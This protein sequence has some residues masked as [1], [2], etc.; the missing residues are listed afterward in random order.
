MKKTVSIILA[1]I[2]IFVVASCTRGN[3][4]VLPKET[5]TEETGTTPA[6]KKVYGNIEFPLSDKKIELTV[7][8]EQLSD[9]RITDFETNMQ[10]KWYEELTN[11]HINWIA[12]PTAEKETKLNLSLASGDYPDIYGGDF[13]T[14]QATLYGG[15]VFRALN[16]LLDGGY[17]P[18]TKSWFEREP[19]ILEALT[20]PDGKLYGFP[21]VSIA[22]HMRA[23]NKLFVK[24]AWLDKLGIDAPTT[25]EEFRNMLIAFRDNDMDGDGDKGNEI[26][27]LGSISS[28]CGDPLIFL[29]NAFQF[30][31]GDYLIAKDNKIIFTANLDTW[32]EGLAYI[33]DLY[34]EGLYAEETFVQDGQQ[35][36]A[37]VGEGIVGVA[38]GAWQGVFCDNIAVPFTD[39]V[40]LLPLKGPAGL[41]QTPTNSIDGTNSVGF[42][43]VIT[44]A[45]KYPE[46]AAQWLDFW[47]SDEGTFISTFGFENESF[48]YS[49]KPAINSKVPSVITYD[50][51]KVTENCMWSNKT[52]PVQTKSDIYYLAAAEEGSQ[53]MLLYEAGKMYI[54]YEVYTGRPL[55]IWSSDTDLEAQRSELGIVI[56]NHVRQATAEFILGT[57]NINSDADWEAYC[58]ELENLELKRYIEITEAIWFGK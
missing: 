18:N 56:G 32:R 58:K 27:L 30:T 21:N 7:W 52:V 45:C 11:V 16:D 41:Q 26:P 19:Y 54:P 40:P 48:E 25:T 17:M 57:R 36:M 23:Q 1:A 34:K 20:A 29:M 2:I 47:V 15:K 55:T 9:K 22:Y 13:S 5:A 42:K 24:K 4:A 33:N 14:S 3:E 12:V 39:Y 31:P 37:L 10:T 8:T 38:A 43:G 53:N 46:I 35:Y 50:N 6:P 28:W 44:V 49:Q 51:E